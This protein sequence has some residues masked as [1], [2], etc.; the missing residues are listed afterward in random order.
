MSIIIDS[1]DDE[2]DVDH[3]TKTIRTVG[4][5]TLNSGTDVNNLSTVEK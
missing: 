4:T 3:S 5:S 1:S 2:L